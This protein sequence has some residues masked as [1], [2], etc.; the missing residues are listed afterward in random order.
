MAKSSKGQ[1]NSR[2]AVRTALKAFLT[3][4]DN[5]CCKT[6]DKIVELIGSGRGYR[7]IDNRVWEYT[8]DLLQKRRDVIHEC[9]SIL[10]ASET[11][12]DDLD[13]AL[14][15]AVATE[16]LVKER[17]QK[18][19][20][21][22]EEVKIFPKTLF[23]PNGVIRL[24]D[25]VESIQIGHVKIVKTR[26]LNTE[27]QKHGFE[28]KVG[29]RDGLQFA[30]GRRF[31]EYP[32]T[33]WEV[34]V[35][36]SRKNVSEEAQWK[37]NIAISLL[38]LGLMDFSQRKGHFPYLGDVEARPFEIKLIDDVKLVVFDQHKVSHGSTMTPCW[39]E[40][41]AATV[42]HLTERKLGDIACAIFDP[43]SK[44]VAERLNEGLGWMTLARQ[45]R[46]R[47]ERFMHFFT[48]LEALLT[49][50]DPNAP[51]TQTIARFLSCILSNKNEDRVSLSKTIIGLYGKRSGLIHG[52]KR[53]EIHRSDVDDLQH[54]T[55]VAYW[56][57]IT[58]V[59][60]VTLNKDF[61]NDLDW[62]SH[63]LEWPRPA[64]SL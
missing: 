49:K 45:T 8:T 24:I 29:S 57:V 61:L 7:M 19:F 28:I 51:V 41:D 50:S 54:F 33:G 52:G 53:S 23:G 60:L 58:K 59:P 38:R 62:A 5:A 34:S 48:A 12:E 3:A 9:L 56:K 14:W 15:A 4:A 16:G 32:D 13:S 11:S 64:P 37:I 35:H 55:E 10:T 2:P 21:E 1:M 46:Q 18:F 42:D 36:S 63:G 40:V 27:A 20:A 44:S 6:Q 31:L 25:P 30:E 47:A 39:Y 43:A 22:I 17:E 26:V